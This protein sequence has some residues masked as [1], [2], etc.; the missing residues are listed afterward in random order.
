MI[1]VT[2]IEMVLK[3]WRTSKSDSFS[4][5]IA[6]DDF[7]DRASNEIDSIIDV[8]KSNPMYYESDGEHL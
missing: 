5:V 6:A 3:M 8:E 4:L 1:H 7:N 2:Q